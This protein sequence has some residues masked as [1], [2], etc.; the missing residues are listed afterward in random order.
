MQRSAV[1]AELLGSELQGGWAGPCH[2]A[3]AAAGPGCGLCPESQHG[4]GS[5]RDEVWAGH[6]LLH[7]DGHHWGVPPAGAFSGQVLV[8]TGAEFS[9][10]KVFKVTPACSQGAGTLR[11]TGGRGVQWH[12]GLACDDI[13]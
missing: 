9:V 13:H 3:W 11:T 8:F 12:P 5:R 10:N 4:V 6:T 7:C 1:G 2:S